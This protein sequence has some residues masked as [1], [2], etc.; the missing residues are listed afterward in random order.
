MH[1][2]APVL[3]EEDLEDLVYVL[4][5]PMGRYSYERASHLS[6]VPKRTLHHWAHEGVFIPDFDGARPKQWSYR[7]LVLVRL[8]VWLREAGHSPVDASVRVEAVRKRLALTPERPPS[9]RGDGQTLLIGTDEFD[10]LTGTQ[11]FEGL[12]EYL[13]V[14]DI[15]TALPEK[16]TPGKLWGPDL[17]K[18]SSWTGISPL[19]MAGEPCVRNT[20]L[21]TGTVW[22]LTTQRHLS[23]D[24]LVELYPGVSRDQLVDA[25]ALESRLR[26]QPIAA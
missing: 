7:D 13:G 11:V 25:L 20:R 18:P 19:V 10:Q 5:R 4:S 24:D 12:S 2:L 9:I 23:P 3:S 14:F 21:T 6:G 22:A 15:T 16:A 26:R 17:V 8:L 1:R